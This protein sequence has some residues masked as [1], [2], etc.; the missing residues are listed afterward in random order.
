VSKL[1]TNNDGST[2]AG[3]GF[4][5][6]LRR[7][8]GFQG[9]QG[10]STRVMS[11]GW[12]SGRSG[13]L[14]VS[15][16]PRSPKHQQEEG[17][18]SGEGTF[19]LAG[20]CCCRGCQLQTLI[21]AESCRSVFTPTLLSVS[22]Q[23]NLAALGRPHTRRSRQHA[24]VAMHPRKSSRVRLKDAAVGLAQLPTWMTRRQCDRAWLCP[25]STPPIPTDIMSQAGRP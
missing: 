13:H 7:H 22:L 8:R 6:W 18:C 16:I 19:C 4:R 23:L 17:S 24:T 9:I 14:P 3:G 21:A 11:L 2:W 10:N 5:V 20:S 12:V 1:E 15:R 25:R